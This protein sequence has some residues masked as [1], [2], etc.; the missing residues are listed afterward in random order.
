MTRFKLKAIPFL[1]SLNADFFAR[2]VFF[3]A[4]VYYM[5]SNSILTIERKVIL[6]NEG[7]DSP[8]RYSKTF[9]QEKKLDAILEQMKDQEEQKE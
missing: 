2:M 5:A 1:R 8:T 9:G 3:V 7:P 6:P 4:F